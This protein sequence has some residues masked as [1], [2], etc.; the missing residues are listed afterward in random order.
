MTAL[1][2]GFVR[3]YVVLYWVDTALT[4][5]TGSLRESEGFYKLAGGNLMKNA[6]VLVLVAVLHSDPCY[7]D[8][9]SGF[10]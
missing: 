2:R 7:G 1:C 8:W 3:F 4:N 5:C 6:L 9:V 10:N